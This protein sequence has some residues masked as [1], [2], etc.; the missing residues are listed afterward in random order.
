MN[1]KKLYRKTSDKM[2]MGV[3]SGIADYFNVDKTII[4][5][6][7]VLISLILGAGLGGIIVYFIAAVI[8]PDENSVQP[9]F[10]GGNG[11]NNNNNNF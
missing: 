7:W 10:D 9:P 6:A 5:L 4:R 2:I 11:Y 1:G 3:C 8:I